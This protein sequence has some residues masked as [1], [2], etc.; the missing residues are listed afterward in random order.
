MLFIEQS[1]VM[2]VYALSL[3]S[4][5]R[6]HMSLGIC[7]IFKAQI[8]DCAECPARTASDHDIFT[9]I[10]L[11]LHYRREFEPALTATARRIWGVRLSFGLMFPGLFIVPSP[12]LF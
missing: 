11:H 1:V 7:S 8:L 10:T 2:D 9:F 3:V 6:H 12:D 4:R 5:L